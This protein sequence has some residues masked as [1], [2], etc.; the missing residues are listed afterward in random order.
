MNVHVV[1]VKKRAKCDHTV[2]ASQRQ[3]S[4]GVKIITRAS[5]CD[6]GRA[7]SSGDGAGDEHSDVRVKV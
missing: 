1:E 5:D 6:R 4:H 2:R 7:V 3:S